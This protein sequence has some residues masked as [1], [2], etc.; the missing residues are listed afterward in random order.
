MDR[1]ALTTGRSPLQDR[2]SGRVSSGVPLASTIRRSIARLSARRPDPF[3]RQHLLTVM[4][5]G[6]H[7]LRNALPTSISFSRRT[8]SHIPSRYAR[9]SLCFAI[10]LL[11]S[12]GHVF[13]SLTGFL[14]SDS[15]RIVPNCP[16]AIYAYALQT[17]MRSGYDDES[18][19]KDW[20]GSTMDTF[21]NKSPPIRRVSRVSSSDPRARERSS[22][23]RPPAFL[24]IACRGIM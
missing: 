9:T 2:R 11:C 13:M 20:G 3:T 4:R 21:Y 1:P 5:R 24:S 8:S 18:W 10:H 14:L 16:T 22:V 17:T 7:P 15:L 19:K 23:C 6:L 12:F